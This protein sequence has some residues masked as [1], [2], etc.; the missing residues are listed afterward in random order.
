MARIKRITSGIA[1]IDTR[2]G[3]PARR[4]DP[5]YFSPE[6]RALIAALKEE[7]GDKCEDCGRGPEGNGEQ[8]RIYGDHV[9]ELKDGGASLDPAN[10]RLR[11]G[12]CHGQKTIGA[13]RQR[14]E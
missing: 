14:L 7:R 5:F 11:C 1:R 8:T 2:V 10:V 13:R 12:T 9:E 3:Q 4:P 6:W